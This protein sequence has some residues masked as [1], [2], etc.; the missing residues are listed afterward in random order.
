MMAARPRGVATEGAERR[1]WRGHA[2][3]R[4]RCEARLG[5]GVLRWRCLGVRSRSEQ[6]LWYVFF[7]FFI[8][9]VGVGHVV[10]HP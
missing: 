10:T 6:L 7:L 8:R 5:R 9:S 4:R 2:E 3:Q 1:R